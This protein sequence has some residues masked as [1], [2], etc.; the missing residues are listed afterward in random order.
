MP[1][2]F[3]VRHAEPLLS[4]VM[5]GRTDSPLSDAGRLE[6]RA[7]LA[8]LPCAVVYS[9]PLLRA[10]ETAAVIPAP[11]VLLDDLAE[12]AYGEWEGLSWNEIERR[13]PDLA[14]RKREDWFAVTPPGGES[15]D[16]VAIRAARA[17]RRIREGPFPAAAVAHFGFNSEF[18][19]QAAGRDPVTFSQSYCEVV[20]VDL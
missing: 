1:Q 14:R 7:R 20:S 9:S 18:L 19:R 13:W 5:L 10:R 3:L 6:A 11:L 4:G 17:L 8:A 12:I 2:L 16:Q 15:W